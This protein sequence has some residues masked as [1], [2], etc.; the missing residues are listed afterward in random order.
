MMAIPVP[1]SQL[2][3]T[4][5]V[6]S[7]DLICIVDVSK[8]VASQTSKMTVEAFT[9]AAGSV[10]GYMRDSTT[11]ITTVATDITNYADGGAVFMTQDLVAGTLTVNSD[12]F[13]L[14]SALIRADYQTLNE[15]FELFI[16]KNGTPGILIGASLA[17]GGSEAVVS[18]SFGLNL[19]AGDFVKLQALVTAGSIALDLA[20]FTVTKV[21]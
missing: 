18:S 8:V 12:G 10:A 15:F 16:S 17:R 14:V 20:N 3:T 4:L 1:I 7:D 9:A 13:Y 11:N 19:V 2:P 6:A 5:E 21:A